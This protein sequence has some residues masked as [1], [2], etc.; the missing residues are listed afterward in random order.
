[1]RTVWQS[2]AS[3]HALLPGS[4]RR[5][6]GVRRQIARTVGGSGRA[7]SCW[8]K[9][10]PGRISAPPRPQASQAIQ[11][12]RWGVPAKMA[13]STTASPPS[14][15]Y[16]RTAS[17]PIECA[18]TAMRDSPVLRFNSDAAAATSRACSM[19]LPYRSRKERQF[20][21]AGSHPAETRKSRQGCSTR[22][23]SLH[24]GTSRTG[25]RRRVAGRSA[26]DSTCSGLGVSCMPAL[27][28]TS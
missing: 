10:L 20:T 15:R 18:T 3:I 23:V 16:F 22:D 24:P 2:A 26:P 13:V 25:A 11:V 19:L 1:M 27:R 21:A 14:S 17:P 12:P 5:S 4:T 9:A 6:I 8:R 7:L 28:L